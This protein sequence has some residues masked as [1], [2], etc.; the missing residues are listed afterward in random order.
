[1]PLVSCA[2]DTALMAQKDYILKLIND[3]EYQSA[4]HLLTFSKKLWASLNYGYKTKEIFERLKR[5]VN[6]KILE[7]KHHKTTKHFE[8]LLNLISTLE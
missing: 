8:E 2:A 1:M 7:S 3:E 6:V 4:L 5:E